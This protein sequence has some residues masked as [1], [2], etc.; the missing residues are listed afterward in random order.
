MMSAKRPVLTPEDHE[1]FVEYGY[2]IIRKAVP[3]ELIDE[4]VAILEKDDTFA[5]GADKQRQKNEV[6]EAC[7]TDTILDAIQEL[8]GDC[9]INR[10]RSS[11]DIPREYTPEAGDSSGLVAIGLHVDD[12]YPTIMPDAWSVRAVVS[13]TPVKPRGG[14][15]IYTPGSPFRFL[16]AMA[17]TPDAMKMIPQ[18]PEF[19]GPPV[20][21]QAEPGDILIIE[22][23]MG[24]SGSTN[25][26]SEIPR[27]MLL[28][29]TGPKQRIVPGAKPFE[30]MSSMEKANS[31]RYLQHRYGVKFQLPQLAD[32]ES[33]T[34]SL[35]HGFSSEGTIVTQECLRYEGTTHLFFVD[36]SQQSVINHAMGDDWADWVKAEPMEFSS[37]PIHGICIFQRGFDV[38]MFVSIG[39]DEGRIEI[40]ESEDL[41]HWS[42]VS[43]ITNARCGV[44][45]INSDWGSKV[46]RGQVIFFVVPGERS[47]LLCRWGNEWCAASEWTDQAESAQAPDGFDFEDVYVKASRGEGRFGLVA[48]LREE[49]TGKSKLYFSDSNDGSIFENE[50]K[51]LHHS[52]MS[53]PYHI[54]VYI[55]ARD[56]WLVTYLCEREGKGRIFWGSID[57]AEEPIRLKELN[58]KE[59][60]EEALYIV[61]L[62]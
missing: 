46:A 28:H 55:R 27:H 11:S 14:G 54:R 37:E 6:L 56:Y 8:H 17:A 20:E 62:K 40:L 45:H 23:R 34:K 24:H 5:I 50:L 44:G 43:S 9:E 4:A 52:A 29:S 18:R 10:N 21:F 13:L 16:A 49:T 31:A 3:P 22:H 35:Q 2:V 33:V 42:N 36:E 39:G 59:A 30:E 7:V 19:A 57:W 12:D 15:Y 60:L 58:S 26:S 51:P 25:V 38:Q 61:G 48:N 47:K 1:H 41:K 53:L 32:E